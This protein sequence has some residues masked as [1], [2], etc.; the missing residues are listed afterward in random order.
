MNDNGYAARRA[1]GPLI[2]EL[3]QLVLCSKRQK[4][5]VAC[6]DKEQ[7]ENLRTHASECF[8]AKTAAAG[9]Q[10]T[11]DIVM[12]NETDIYEAYGKLSEYLLKRGEKGHN[13]LVP[14]CP[15]TSE[16]GLKFRRY[17]SIDAFGIDV[18]PEDILSTIRGCVIN[19]P[20]VITIVHP[21]GIVNG[22]IGINNLQQITKAQIAEKWTDVNPPLFHEA[23]D[24]YYNRYAAANPKPINGSR[25]G[26][27]M[28]SK[29]YESGQGSNGRFYKVR[30]NR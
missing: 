10:I 3:Y 19:G 15:A 7:F 22:N 12:E 8:G 27:I 6:H 24:S 20:V 13:S 16:C 25:L 28:K 23:R 17:C 21:G 9:N 30:E 18:K 2:T 5:V 1:G 4:F 29:G 11:V 14:I 26:K